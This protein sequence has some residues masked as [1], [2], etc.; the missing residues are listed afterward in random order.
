VE[1]GQIDRIVERLRR[2]QSVALAGDRSGIAPRGAVEAVERELRA[3][4]RTI[5]WV[6]LDGAESGA[7]LGGRIVEGCMRHLDPDDLGD[8]LEQLPSRGRIDLEALAELLMLPER[9]AAS[10][11]RR[12]VTILEGFH[13]VER[14]IGFGGLGAVRDALVLRQRVAYLFVGARR[15]EALFGRPDM[16]LYGLAEVVSVGGRDAARGRPGAG[17]PEERGRGRRAER[18]LEP[19]ASVERPPDDPLAAALLSWAEAPPKPKPE[20]ER[21]P[22]EWLVAREAAEREWLDR[23][24]RG[25]RDDDRWWRRG[26]R[27]R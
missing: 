22:W 15:V 27:R 23:L 5:V 21:E 13:Q 6:D 17:G 2:G 4:G 11:G 3:L 18:P 9:I 12:V 14:A 1:P 19:P 10:S 26:R 8:V 24:E 20:P 16:P 7:E 25:E